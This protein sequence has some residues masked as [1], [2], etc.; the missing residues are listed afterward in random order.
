MS[1]S[2]FLKQLDAFKEYDKP[3]RVFMVNGIGL[4]GKLVDYDEDTILLEADQGHMPT[5]I[6][7]ENVLSV[8]IA[9]A[10]NGHSRRG[11]YRDE[12]ADGNRDNYRDRRTHHEQHCPDNCSHRQVR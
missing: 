3:L 10:Q 1:D 5:L 11:G 4:T 8:A 2:L 9:T 6:N 7:R 12:D